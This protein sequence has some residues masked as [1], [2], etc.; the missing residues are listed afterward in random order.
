[1]HYV[2]SFHPSAYCV[3]RGHRKNLLA[4]EYQCIKADNL[5]NF[6]KHIVFSDLYGGLNKNVYDGRSNL[7]LLENQAR[8]SLAR[9]RK[10]RDLSG[11][12][13]IISSTLAARAKPPDK[14]K[15]FTERYEF[16]IFRKIMQLRGIDVPNE[17]CDKWLMSFVVLRR[18][19]QSADT[20]FSPYHPKA[21]KTLRN[22]GTKVDPATLVRKL[23]LSLGRMEFLFNR[24]KPDL[25]RLYEHIFFKRNNIKHFNSMIDSKQI[26]DTMTA[27]KEYGFFIPKGFKY[28][29]EKLGKR[30][31]DLTKDFLLS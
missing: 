7:F 3:Q 31:F 14:L 27:L 16:D 15:F 26:T 25:F 24:V 12:L 17:A 8:N 28:Y 19:I 22:G 2:P 4:T 30:A 20:V 11:P 10:S 9:A 23:W 18:F 29:S 6:K 5:V 13:G 1:M 21:S